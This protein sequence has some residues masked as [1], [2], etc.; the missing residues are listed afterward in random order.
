MTS[1]KGTIW[2]QFLKPI[3]SL[4][5]IDEQEIKRLAQSIDWDGECDRF[6]N[7]DVI[8][9]DYYSNQN[10]HGIEGG[11][12]N[13]TAAVTYDPITNYLL[14]PGE[15]IIR[16]GLI[17]A[18][19]IKPRK[20]LDLGCGTG[21]TTIMLKRAFPDA[22][23]IGID[24]STYMLVMADYKAKKIGLDIT[25]LQANAEKTGFKADSFDLVTA[26]LLLHETPPE[27]SKNILKESQRLLRT[28]G[29]VI[30]LDGNQQTLRNTA[31]LT[32]IFEEPYLENYAQG[33]V[34]GWMGNAGLEA[35]RT[36]DLWFTNQITR[37]YKG[38]PINDIIT[39]ENWQFA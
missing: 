14:P 4:F 38:I 31:W 11:Y 39:D 12:L 26:A 30:V 5:L 28:G 21:T 18:I 13:I 16:Q 36:D 35:I 25:F 24:L 8:Y 6:Q 32:N 29:E 33:S 10:F 15:N 34:D 27:I 3:F 23:V 22:E 2:E 37:G 20:I 9:P 1:T 17:D 19:N 7:P